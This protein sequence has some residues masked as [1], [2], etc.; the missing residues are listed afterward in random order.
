MTRTNEEI[1]AAQPVGFGGTRP[2]T[3]S[4]KSVELAADSA[5]AGR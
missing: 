5:L 2:A 3:F 1:G 4:V